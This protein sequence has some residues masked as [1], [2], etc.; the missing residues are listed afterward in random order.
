MIGIILLFEVYVTRSGLGGVK[1]DE[2]LGTP[3]KGRLDVL[4]TIYFQVLQENRIL[5]WRVYV[6]RK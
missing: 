4:R 3:I 6:K 1:L 2:I 5:K